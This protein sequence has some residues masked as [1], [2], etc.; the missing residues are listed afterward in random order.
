MSK[1]NLGIVKTSLL[2]NLNEQIVLKQFVNLLKESNLLRLTYGIF[3]N[4]E[5]KYIPNEDLAIKYI[6]SNLKVVKDSGYTKE[7]FYKEN[8]KY[9]PLIEGIAFAKSENVKLYEHIDSLIYESLNGKKQ[10]NVNKLHDSFSFVLEHLKKEKQKPILEKV[11]LP[12]DIIYDDFI[13]KK[14][15]FE[16]NQK[17][18]GQLLEEEI[19]LLKSIVNDT[20]E[21]KIDSF[22][23]IKENTLKSLTILK[24]ELENKGQL[25]AHEQRETNHFISKIHESISNIEK[26]QYSDDS[27][28]KDVIDLI[29]LKKEIE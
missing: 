24:T 20:A 27:Y 23:L 6:D 25:P 7:S 15:I 9:L 21:T 26:L 13:L 4:F 8:E 1:Y 5:N 14:A 17:Y 19:I 3:E 16:F 2:S 10:T 12:K 18:S 29:S 11:D 22:N 28:M